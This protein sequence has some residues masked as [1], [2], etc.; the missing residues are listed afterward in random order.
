[1]ISRHGSRYPT[2]KSKRRMESIG[3][4][5]DI[6]VIFHQDFSIL[7]EDNFGLLA[8]RG[9]NELFSFGERLFK[10]YSNII[11]KNNWFKTQKYHPKLFDISSSQKNRVLESAYSFTLG[12]FKNLGEIS[13]LNLPAV[14]IK[15]TSLD[16]DLIL[17]FHKSCPKYEKKTKKLKNSLEKTVLNEIIESYEE[18]V[19]K[20]LKDYKGLS[21]KFDKKDEF[22]KKLKIQFEACQIETLLEQ[23]TNFCNVFNEYSD[24][25]ELMAYFD[26]AVQYFYKGNS[27]KLNT[28]MS[29]LLRD[30]ITS[31]FTNSTTN[32]KV[33]Y[34][35][36]KAL[37]RF[38]H[39]ETLLPLLS[40]IPRL[41]DN[42]DIF[43]I[44]NHFQSEKVRNRK[45]RTGYLIPMGANIIFELL[46]CVDGDKVRILLNE[47]EVY[48]CHESELCSV[49][50]LLVLFQHKTCNF[51]EL[52]ERNEV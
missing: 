44:K 4:N 15:S 48:I 17:R 42:E 7:Q 25:L 19:Y 38:A 24:I 22:L 11:T 45:F 49:E 31:F 5:L 14:S 8:K 37:F 1:M 35:T 23:N 3:I 28:E 12:F 20:T 30:E 10:R 21:F 26:D 40:G 47:V 18:F 16:N 2:G 36:Q 33:K 46:N 51:D 50:E 43:T 52:C 34:K 41:M 29:C 13:E 9:K 39:A 32:L 27:D 6:N